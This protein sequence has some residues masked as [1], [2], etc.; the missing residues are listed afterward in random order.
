MVQGEKL[1]TNDV[2]KNLPKETRECIWRIMDQLIITRVNKTFK[3]N[4]SFYLNEVNRG[5]KSMQEIAY[6][7]PHSKEVKKIHVDIKPVLNDI[8]HVII[9]FQGEMLMTFDY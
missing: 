1:L 8:V 2:M 7:D 5:G 9:Q 6:Y 4:Y 3:S